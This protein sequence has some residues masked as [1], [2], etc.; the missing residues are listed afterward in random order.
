MQTC[1]RV[2]S[3]YSH[4]SHVCPGHEDCVHPC[5]IQVSSSSPS[6]HARPLP[7]SHP[8]I[9]TQSLTLAALTSK[10]KFPEP[11]EYENLVRYIHEVWLLSVAWPETILAVVVPRD[12]RKRSIVQ[13]EAIRGTRQR[14][15]PQEDAMAWRDVL[16]SAC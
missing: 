7:H 4:P 12:W 16:G 10:V 11:W 2:L 3:L 13:A 8:P 1:V 5:L 9:P 6:L 15:G 14:L